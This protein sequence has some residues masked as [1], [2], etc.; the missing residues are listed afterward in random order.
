[1][2]TILKSCFLPLFTETLHFPR[3]ER[4]WKLRNMTHNELPWLEAR[5]GNSIITH[6]SLKEYFKTQIVNDGDE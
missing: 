2:E 6:Q 4:G 5:A 3:P 1:M